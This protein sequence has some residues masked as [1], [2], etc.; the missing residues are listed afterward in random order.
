MS[1][2]GQQPSLRLQIYLKK[3]SALFRKNVQR[4]DGS[5]RIT[6]DQQPSPLLPEAMKN[7]SGVI[8]TGGTQK[9]GRWWAMSGPIRLFSNLSLSSSS[10]PRPPTVNESMEPESSTDN[11]I[12]EGQII[13]VLIKMPRTNSNVQ[14]VLSA[15]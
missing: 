14:A 12:K 9:Q 15:Q 2:E 11:S 1:R 6:E 8:E 13:E 5:N 3:E 10:S 7:K 4:E